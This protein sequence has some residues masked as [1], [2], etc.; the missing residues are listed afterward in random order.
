MAGQTFY[1]AHQY[2]LAID[3]FR[4]TLDMEPNYWVARTLLG[5]SYE[6][7]ATFL[8][9]SRSVRKAGK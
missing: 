4:K 3:T 2:D 7:K 1:F 5:A 6:A 8:V 9:P